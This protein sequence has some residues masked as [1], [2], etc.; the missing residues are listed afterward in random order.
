ME[1]GIAIAKRHH[2]QRRITVCGFVRIVLAL[3]RTQSI[4]DPSDGA[5]AAADDDPDVGNLPE[6]LQPR[7]GPAF[8]QVVHLSEKS[9]SAHA[10]HIHV[11]KARLKGGSTVVGMLQAEPGRS[12]KQEH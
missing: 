5:V 4:Q 11:S 10:V 7:G 1:W 3:Q 12:G 9:T 6:H 2:W 8:A